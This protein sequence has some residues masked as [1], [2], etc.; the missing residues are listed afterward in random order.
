MEGA[1]EE[2]RMN[3]QLMEQNQKT[4]MKTGQASQTCPCGSA[5]SSHQTAACNVDTCTPNSSGSPTSSSHKKN[6]VSFSLAFA[7]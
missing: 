1:A 6:V 7:P 3:K 5:D 2:E 4:A